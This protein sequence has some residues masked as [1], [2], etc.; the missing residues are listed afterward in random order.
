[1]AAVRVSRDPMSPLKAVVCKT[2]RALAVAE[3]GTS[4]EIKIENHAGFIRVPV[5][6]AGPLKIAGSEGTNGDFFAPLATVEPTLVASC[7][8]GSKAFTASGGLEFK[9]LSEGMSRAPV[10]FFSTPAEALGFAGRVPALRD[11]F[12]RAAEATSR[13]ARL[14]TLTPHVVGANVHLCFSY[15]TG[16]A[17]GQN[18]V[19]IATQAACDDFLASDAAQELGVR[20]FVIEGDMASDKKGS[21]R[22]A[23]EPRGVQV[24]AWGNITHEVCVRVLKCSTE[25][26][27]TVLMLMKEGQAR[28]G[29]FGGNVNTANVVAA[30][31][32]ACGQDA[33]SVAESAWTH[34]TTTYDAD[35]K[36]LN[37]S[38]FFPSLPVGTV[39][40]GTMY[41]SQ[42]VSLELLRCQDPGS[43]RRLA[44]LV[45]CFCMAL[46]VSTAAAIASGGF[47]DAHKKLARDRLDKS[48][49]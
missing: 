23:M 17:A 32:I 36:K 39:G 9:V 7:S 20:D 11:E 16:D 3:A 43:K 5:G 44:G 37:L 22:N 6:I 24:L 48:K 46:D 4:S 49:L 10:F 12:A 33:G 29:G 28:N 45:A 21:W 34:L 42:K 38:L 26:L 25:R 13:F 14:Q 31:F 19:T 35:S 40:G 27:Y 41:P 47:T 15:A 1:M 30:M 8:R 18:M 2:S